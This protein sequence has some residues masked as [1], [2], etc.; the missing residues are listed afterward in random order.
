MVHCQPPVA[1][2]VIECGLST[3]EDDV[4]SKGGFE[5]LMRLAQ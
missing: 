4:K 2:A 5:L 1:A 3:T